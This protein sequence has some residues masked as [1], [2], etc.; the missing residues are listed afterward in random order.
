MLEMRFLGRGG[1]GAVLAAELLAEAAFLD[2]KVPQSFPFFGV[3]R[4]GAPV[5][6]YCRVHD[7]PI[8]VRG[9]VAEPDLLVVLDRS[10]LRSPGATSGIRDHG[11]VLVNA[12]PTARSFPVPAG[13]RLAVVDASRIAVE[14]RLGSPTLPIVNTVVLGAVARLTGVVSLDALERAIEHHVPRNREENRAAC[15]DGFS[16]V[17]VLEGAEFRR[18]PVPPGPALSETVPDG[19]VASVSSERVSTASWRTLKPE[20][21][22]EKCTRCNFCWK[23]C[24]DVAIDFDARGYPVVAEEH[25]KGCGICAEVCPPKAIAMVEEA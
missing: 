18:P 21:H 15:R 6:A 1:Q 7:G 4:R 16:K 13:A 8:A 10:L 22:L 5:T 11:W 2:G 14:H 23:Y 24:P 9:S 17:E 20:I 3:E 12:P 25:C 19:P